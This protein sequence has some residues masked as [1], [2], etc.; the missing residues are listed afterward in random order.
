MQQFI[1]LVFNFLLAK[2]D[3]QCLSESTVTFILRQKHYF[4]LITYWIN[5]S[6][7]VLELVAFVSLVELFLSDLLEEVSVLLVH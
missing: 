6:E 1:N 4:S 5:C 3:H 7:E 2:D